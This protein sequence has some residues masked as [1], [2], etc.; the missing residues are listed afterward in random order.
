MI[1]VTVELLPFGEDGD[2]NEIL[3]VMLLS[4]DLAGSLR[5]GGQRGN[6]NVR[7][8]KKRNA[9]NLFAACKLGASHL[10]SAWA[11]TK[12]ENYPRLAYHPWNLVRLALNQIY[13]NNQ[14][15]MI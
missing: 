15:R 3:G 4:N 2:H 12:V 11:E 10:Y 1:R 5:S 14:R 7:L 6:Y 13:E 8:W 9:A